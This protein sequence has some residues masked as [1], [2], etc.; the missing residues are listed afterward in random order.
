MKQNKEVLSVIGSL[1]LRVGLCL[2]G[3]CLSQSVFAAIEVTCLWGDCQTFGWNLRHESSLAQ[4]QVRCMYEDCQTF[5]WH[6]FSF[7]GQVFKNYCEPGGCWVEGWSATD[8][9]GRRVA[10]AMCHA[11]DEGQTDCL[12][13]GWT[14]YRRRAIAAHVTCIENDCRR[15][16]WKISAPYGPPQYALC[17]RDGCFVQGWY[18]YD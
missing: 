11:G 13:Y 7:D 17:K 5:G 10:K 8:R 15:Q 12:T 9:K 14:V 2:V 3:L 6:E 16:G 18:L 4:G 1:A